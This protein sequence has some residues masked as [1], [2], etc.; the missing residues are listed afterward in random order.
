MNDEMNAARAPQVR[1]WI[2]HLENTTEK[3]LATQQELSQ[4]LAGVLRVEPMAC[5]DGGETKEQEQLVPTANAL[6]EICRMV[7]HVVAENDRMIR[8]LEI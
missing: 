6:R 7:E 2:S 3:A 5:K 8:Q 1:D 4:R